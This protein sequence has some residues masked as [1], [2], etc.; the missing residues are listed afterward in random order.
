MFRHVGEK[1]GKPTKTETRTGS[2]TD[3]RRPEQTSPYNNTSRLKTG[4]YKR[5]FYLLTNLLFVLAWNYVNN[6]TVEAMTIILALMAAFLI[7]L[8]RLTRRRP[9]FPPGP[10]SYPLIGSFP[11]V[12]F[13][14]LLEEMRL[15]RKRYGDVYSIMISYKVSDASKSPNSK[16]DAERPRCSDAFNVIYSY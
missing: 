16:S 10:P 9:A 15:L 3:G 5:I 8:W 7:F 4:V 12:D 14:N 11:C 13:S 2:R 1:C 6:M